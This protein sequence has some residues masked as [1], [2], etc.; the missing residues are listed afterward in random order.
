LPAG[1]GPAAQQLGD[2]L[3]EA[4]EYCRRGDHL[5]T[6]AAPREELL[7]P[8]VPRRVRRPARRCTAHALA[9]LL[10]RLSIQRPSRE[11]PHFT[12][13]RARQRAAAP[14]RSG[15]GGAS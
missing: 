9:R 13:R 2:M 10:G 5:L 7:P 4:D 6:L 3:D 14:R 12:V 15:S 1:V 8:M 11:R